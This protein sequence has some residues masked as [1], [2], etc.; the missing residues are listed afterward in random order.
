MPRSK[1][2]T[3]KQSASQRRKASNIRKAINK[4]ENSPQQTALRLVCF[5]IGFLRRSTKMFNIT[6]DFLIAVVTAFVYYIIFT[7]ITT[8]SK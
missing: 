1:H 4:F 7:L 2:P 5:Q 8:K 3:K 6:N